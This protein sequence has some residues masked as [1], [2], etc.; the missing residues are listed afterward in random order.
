L[1]FVPSTGSGESEYLFRPS[2]LDVFRRKEAGKVMAD[3]LIGCVPFDSFGAVIPTENPAPCVHQK[4]G[5]VL[6]SIEEHPK[7]FFAVLQRQGQRASGPILPRAPSASGDGH[8]Q[9]QGGSENQ[10]SFGLSE[11]LFGFRTALRQQ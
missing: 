9:A 7:L 2:T 8:Q 5:V 6:N 1:F 4:N 11:A 10:N 3:Y